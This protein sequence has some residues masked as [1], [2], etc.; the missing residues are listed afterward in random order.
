MSE[1]KILKAT[2]HFF[3]DKNKAIHHEEGGKKEKEGER[4]KLTFRMLSI[5]QADTFK[6]NKT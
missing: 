1:Y 3:A 2:E 4:S 6:P 5:L